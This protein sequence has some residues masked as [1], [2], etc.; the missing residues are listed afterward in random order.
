MNFTI[1]NNCTLLPNNIG[2]YIWAVN[3]NRKWII[4]TRTINTDIYLIFSYV[5][6]KTLSF[7][8]YTKIHTKHVKHIIKETKAFT[9]VAFSLSLEAKIPDKRIGVITNSDINLK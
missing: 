9:A 7:L 8:K 6:L 4:I 2:T 1:I 3:S 5:L